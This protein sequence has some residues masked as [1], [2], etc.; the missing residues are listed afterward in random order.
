MTIQTEDIAVF[1]AVVR[2]GSFGRAASSLLVSQPA[3]SERVARLERETGAP[4]FN[5]S[6]RGVTLTPAGEAFLP[7]AR[8][9]VDLLDDAITTVQALDD[10]PRLRVAVHTTFAHRVVPLVLR[11]LGT[12]RRSVKVRDAHSDSIIAMLIDGACDIGFVVPGARPRPLRF[13]ALPPDPMVA[14]VAPT[15]PLGGAVATYGDLAGHRLAFTRFGE[16]AEEFVDRLRR[17]GVPQWSWT[18]CSDAVTALHLA[19]RHG[20]VALVTK[21]LSESHELSDSIE[22]LRLRPAPRWTMPLVFACRRGGEGDP[23]VTAVRRAV[24]HLASPARKGLS[25]PAKR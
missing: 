24:E 15:H 13:V 3:V 2:D 19:A 9:T 18:E 10:A 4:L 6:S 11:A 7:Y 22:R 16:G 8:R 5:R 21:S 17:A 1:L 14:V 20:H 12:M 25:P 23:A